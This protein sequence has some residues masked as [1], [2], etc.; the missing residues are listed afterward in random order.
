[1]HDVQTAKGKENQLT[2]LLPFRKFAILDGRV[3]V[4][5][6]LQEDEFE[7]YHHIDLILALRERHRL[8]SPALTATGWIYGEGR[9]L[10]ASVV[11]LAGD[12]QHVIE[13]ARD[14]L[15]EWAS[16]TKCRLSVELVEDDR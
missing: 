2:K 8:Q 6:L 14:V 1:M 3:L 11:P 7:D 4:G 5:R 16:F 12:A 13:M 9:T 10:T 15:G